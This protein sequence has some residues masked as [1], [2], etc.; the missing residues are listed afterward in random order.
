[1]GKTTPHEP[2]ARTPAPTTADL[3]A[4]GRLVPLNEAA[5]RL[6][7]HRTT[8]YDLAA[9]GRL[10]LVRH[11]GGH[12]TYVRDTELQRYLAEEVEP[13]QPQSQTGSTARVRSGPTLSTTLADLV[14]AKRSR[15]AGAGSGSPTTSTGPSPNVTA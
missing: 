14:M 4:Q 11:P 8:I 7:V 3:V 1:M 5:G 2:T 13:F 10:E 9:R 15:R 6:G 12:R